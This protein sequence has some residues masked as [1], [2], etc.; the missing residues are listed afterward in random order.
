[1]TGNIDYRDTE[2]NT[3]NEQNVV[4]ADATAIGEDKGKGK[5]QED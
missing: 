3:E 1:M 2:L 4:G 5:V